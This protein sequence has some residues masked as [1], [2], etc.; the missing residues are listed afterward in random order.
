MF[1][2]VF[3]TSLQLSI[4]W[5]T[6]I[7]YM[8]HRST[9]FY[10]SVLTFTFAFTVRSFK[11]PLTLKF[12]HQNP[13]YTSINPI[14]ASRSAHLILIDFINIITVI[15]ECK[16]WIYSLLRLHPSPVTSSLLDPNIPLGILLPN[17]LSLCSSVNATN[18]ALHR[19]KTTGKIVVL[20]ICF[21]IFR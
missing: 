17:I 13:L 6:S 11:L 20:Y 7:H 1:I 3:K 10:L 4:S 18:Q 5:A 19:Y 16:S 15:E 14:R 2:T 9:Y 12:P 21:Y 8:P